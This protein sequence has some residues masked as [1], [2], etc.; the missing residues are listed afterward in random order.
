MKREYWRETFLQEHFAL[1]SP[2]ISAISMESLRLLNAVSPPCRG[3]RRTRCSLTGR[4]KRE[5]EVLHESF[6][7]RS[8]AIVRY[9]MVAIEEILRN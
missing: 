7:V 5:R 4:V 6:G 9:V 2:V 1:V 8:R 3:N